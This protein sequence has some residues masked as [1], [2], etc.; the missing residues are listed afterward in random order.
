M[1]TS[2]QTTLPQAPVNGLAK[3]LTKSS[4]HSDH[5]NSSPL[6]GGKR[7]LTSS[8]L[9]GGEV[10]ASESGDLKGG[11]YAEDPEGLENQREMRP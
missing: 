8:S 3:K 4:T 11:T 10:V 9:Q 7:A 6:N 2:G 1:N 5:D